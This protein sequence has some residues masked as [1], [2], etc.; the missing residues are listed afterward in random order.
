[1][2]YS[3]FRTQIHGI[4]TDLLA[5]VPVADPVKILRL[6]VHNTSARTRRLL[7]SWYVEWVL[8]SSRA[9]AAAHIVTE[10]D[11]RRG[12]ILASNRWNTTFGPI[13]GFAAM[14]GRAPRV[15]GDRREFIG[16][17]GVLSWPTALARQ[18][19]LSGRV[20]AG[21]D[22][23]AALQT[24]LELRPGESVEVLL[25][26]GASD[27]AAEAERLIDQ[28]AVADLDATLDA[29]RAQWEA[30]VCT[31]QVRTPDRSMDIMLNA[32]L[33][34]QTLACRVWARAGLYQASGAFGFRDQLQ[35][36]MALA[37]VR[38]D[39]TRAHLLRAAGRQ[40]PEGDVQHWWLPPRGQ[41][42][43]TRISD[44]RVWLAHAAM[45]YV[46][47]S[48]DAA[49]LDEPVAFLD[50]RP[51]AAHE[52]EAYFQPTVSE[53]AVSLFE[54]CALGLDAALATGAHGL[55]LIGT[56]D[57]ND[58]LSRVGEAGAGESVWLGFF[59]YATLLA[60]APVAEARGEAARASAWRAH[61]STLQAALEREAW[62]G[63]WYR[64]GFFDDGTPLGSVASSECRIDAIAQSWSVISGAA[65]PA[66]AVRAMAAMDEQLIRRHDG[67]ALLFAPP[68][69]R[70]PLDP[71]YIKGYPPG[72]RENGGQYTHAALWSVIAYAIQGEG[73][74]AAEL[75]AMVNPIN[76]ALSAADAHRYK[77]EPYAV[78]AD[79]Y[80]AS[81]H[82]GRGGWTWYT[83]SAGWM[84]RAGLEYLLGLH[85][86]GE[87]LRI[88][89][90]IPRSWPGYEARLR[91]GVARYVVVVENPAGAR[92]GV[93]Q[94]WFDGNE[95]GERPVRVVLVD[96]GQE[97]VIRL[98]LG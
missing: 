48:G 81:G 34:Y 9:A 91:H 7:V 84:Y 45:H 98:V 88:E 57:W 93:A 8:G 21:L 39:L 58:G 74:R 11:S 12:A 33:L 70:T 13:V 78:A 77:V 80:A 25:L 40:F 69:D 60:L 86:E 36:G 66:R 92:T 75:F 62:D 73:E 67:L 95:I 76:H 14:P 16:R 54:H 83:G 43:R 72:L 50:G 29:V 82:V 38:P 32:W 55:P 19:P 3:R 18:L 2:G 4:E 68:F 5:F 63:S 37:S 61:A 97:H 27:T 31:V 49:V 44:D 64:R 53:I 20:G 65:D 42:V 10:H 15:S 87:A 56:G 22:P 46:S 26:L 89:P 59:L 47:V 23:C 90:C 52:H 85:R 51:L 1:M 30:V 96:D 41:G 17:N 71:G 79:I 94:A 28:Y 35:D 24:S 6:V